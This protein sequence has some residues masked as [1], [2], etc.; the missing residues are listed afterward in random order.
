MGHNDREGN[1]QHVLIIAGRLHHSY[2]P[3]PRWGAWGHARAQTGLPN[4]SG[5]LWASWTRSSQWKVGKVPQR[6]RCSTGQ[7]LPCP[8]HL[9][10]CCFGTWVGCQSVAAYLALR[11]DVH[12]SCLSPVHRSPPL[13]W[14]AFNPSSVPWR[15]QE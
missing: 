6:M 2:L 4:A 5:G 7:H 12:I 1:L 3:G 8:P 9:L 13:M 15:P 14:H 11:P 10:P